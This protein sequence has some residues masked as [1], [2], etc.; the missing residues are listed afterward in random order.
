M[1]LQ[2]LSN[3]D[4]LTDGAAL[5]I[6]PSIKHSE[7][8]R[9]LDWPLNLQITRANQHQPPTLSLELQKIAHENAIGFDFKRDPRKPLLIVTDGLLPNRFTA[10]VETDN[11][12]QWLSTGLELWQNL[13]MP[14]LRIFLPNFTKW[15][16][17]QSSW[18]QW[19]DLENV[20]IVD[21]GG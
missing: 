6:L 14:T 1:K 20:T 3:D 7:W 8:T 4:A 16:R 18:P 9:N 11:W 15:K 19:A 13:K 5:W 12:D 17:V 2:I 21:S 10:I